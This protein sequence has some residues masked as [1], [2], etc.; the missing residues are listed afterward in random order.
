MSSYDHD[1]RAYVA[2]WIIKLAAGAFLTASLAWANHITT[3]TEGL[4]TA[5]AVQAQ[6]QTS[7]Q[8]QLSRIEA[9]LDRVLE[10]GPNVSK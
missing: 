8:A 9:K 6:V 3:K 4:A 2:G 7:E 10:E 1:G 5:Q